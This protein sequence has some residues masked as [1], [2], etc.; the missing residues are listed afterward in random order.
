MIEFNLNRYV[1]VKLTPA[2][3]NF[4]KFKHNELKKVFPVLG[5]F[6]PPEID[7]EGWS[8]FQLWVLM[9]NFGEIITMGRAA[10]FETTIKIIT[11][12]GDL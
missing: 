2:G 3:L 12:E 1:M 4:L 6:T 8:K 9:K 10:P 7:S 5:D 11:K